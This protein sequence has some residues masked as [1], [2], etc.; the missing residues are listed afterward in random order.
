MT[1]MNWGFNRNLKNHS[2]DIVLGMSDAIV[3]IGSSLIGLTFALASTRLVAATG[4][5]IG[6]AASLSMAVSEYFAAREYGVKKPITGAV[7]TGV[8]YL[9][10]VILLI[11][12]YLLFTSTRAALSTLG[13]IVIV[14]IAAY[15]YYISKRKQESFTKRFIQMLAIS[16]IV[17]II[18]F[19]SGIL[20]KPLIN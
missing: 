17:G 2:G 14:I 13:A 15:T 10:V 20:V 9:L 16:F 18:S 8:T 4:I 3:E 11:A 1:K 6:L 5:I 7:Y 19:I 12:P